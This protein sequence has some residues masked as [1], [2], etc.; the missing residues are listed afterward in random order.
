[1]ALLG[2]VSVGTVKAGSSGLAP[3]PAVTPTASCAC[4]SVKCGSRNFTSLGKN[5]CFALPLDTIASPSIHEARRKLFLARRGPSPPHGLESKRALQQEEKQEDSTGNSG[6]GDS[7]GEVV[8]AEFQGEGESASQSKTVEKSKTVGSPDEIGKALNELRKERIA[9]G[10]QDATSTSNFWQGVTEETK[11]IE[12][13]TL[14]KVLGTT[15]VVVAMIVGSSVVLLT[16][17][18]ILAEGSDF[19]FNNTGFKDFARGTF[20]LYWNLHRAPQQT[21]P[22]GTSDGHT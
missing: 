12:W 16:V 15:G 19:L 21:S 20:G 5:G 6:T 14:P 3:Y 11:L 8:E 17:N 7:D 22:S 10:V 4:V 9:S 13:P 1:M 2:V 18:A